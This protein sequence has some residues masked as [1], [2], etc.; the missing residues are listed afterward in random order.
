[1]ADHKWRWAYTAIGTS[2]IVLLLVLI[3]TDVVDLVP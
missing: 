1:M 2:V 3:G